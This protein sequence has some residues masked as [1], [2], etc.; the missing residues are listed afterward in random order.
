[1]VHLGIIPDG[2]RRWCKANNLPSEQLPLVWE[3]KIKELILE[4]IKVRQN[5]G[6]S[7]LK[8]I[9]QISFYICS[10]DNMSRND[11]TNLI[12]IKF[13]N[14]VANILINPSLVFEKKYIPEIE[15]V[16][17][18]LKVNFIG[19]LQY[20]PESTRTKL[21]EVNKKCIGN[22]VVNLALVYNY[23]NDL[24]QYCIQSNSSYKREQ[25]NIDIVFR[26]GGE[27][28]LSGFFPN[29]TIYSELYFV[30]KLWPD[31]KIND[32]HKC[33]KYYLTR[34]RRFGK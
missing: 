13:M 1:M 25:A 30:K 2:N 3:G 19:E 29:K 32:I 22:F 10:I 26:S 21:D 12:I 28:R 24:G 4:C 20:L 8:Q 23:D 16:I 5:H 34:E 15:A 18:D 9:T 14:S 11:N 33:I 27:Q 31:V 17:A 6:N 7:L